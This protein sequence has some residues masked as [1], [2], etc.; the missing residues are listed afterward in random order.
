MEQILFKHNRPDR[1][2]TCDEY[3]AE[4]GFTALRTALSG[5]SPEEVQ[6]ATI[7]SGLRGRGGDSRRFAPAWQ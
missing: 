7:D 2:I 1:V 5:M 3:R 4:E 6:Q